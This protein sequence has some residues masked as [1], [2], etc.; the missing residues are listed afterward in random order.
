MDLDT[1]KQKY[2]NLSSALGLAKFWSM[3][4][5]Y[6]SY[7]SANVNFTLKYPY[8]PIIFMFNAAIGGGIGS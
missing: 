2:S 1:N 7:Y 8:N 6:I 5:K 3:S 4:S